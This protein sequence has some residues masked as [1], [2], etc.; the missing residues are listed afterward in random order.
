MPELAQKASPVLIVDDDPINLKVLFTALEEAGFDVRVATNAKAALESIDQSPPD[1]VLLDV[2]MPGTNGFEVSRLLQSDPKARDIPIIFLTA[3]TSSEDKVKGLNL[4]GVDYI[5]KPFVAEEVVV[6]VRRHLTIHHLRRQLGE[7]NEHLQQANEAL[8]R[9]IAARTQAEQQ[10]LAQ[11][12]QLAASQERERIGQELHDDLGQVMSY[13]S[14]QTQTALTLLGQNEQAQTEA[15]LEKLTQAAQGAHADLRKYI[16]GIRDAAGAPDFFAALGDYLALLRERYG[17][18]IEMRVPGDLPDAPFDLQ[19]EWQLLRIIQEA[20]TNVG[21][22]A[23]VDSA[24]LIFQIQDGWM[25]VTV[26]DAGRGFAPHAPKEH[27]HFG[28]EMMRERALS[29]GG[30]LE[31]HSA[32]GQ[33]A[34]VTVHV[35]LDLLFLQ[36]EGDWADIRSLRV[37]LADD[38]ALFLEGLGTML[39][40]RGIQVVGIARDGIEAETLALQLHPDVILMDVQMPRC[41]GVAATRQ[42]LTQLPDVK[43]VMLTVAAD[44]DTLFSA[45]KAGASGYLLKSLD[46]VTLFNMLTELMRDQVVLAPGLAARVLAEFAGGP[47]SR[48]LA[49]SVEKDIGAADD[50]PPAADSSQPLTPRQIEVLRLIAQGVTYKGAGVALYISERTIKYHM[51]QILKRL[52]L[53]TR[54]QAIAYAMQEGLDK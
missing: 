15:L 39:T 2:L 44:D 30:R 28:L 16:L 19:V 36:D 3:L 54:A 10:L 21:K 5:T 53:K 23:G 9:E 13:I 24:Q 38:H 18:D 32:L 11:E 20:V 7:Q 8:S 51:G 49:P 31:I 47:S 25:A 4:G 40:T 37:L 29:F 48:P 22:Y 46:S 1:L 33:G 50:A 6:R 17:L 27:G 45:L 52:Q 14:L 34:R 12:R 43:I 26:R 35:P 42:I 41:D